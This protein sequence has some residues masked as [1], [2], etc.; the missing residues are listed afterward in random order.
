MTPIERFDS[1]DSARR[2][3]LLHAGHPDL[4]RRIA[5][6]WKL[7]KALVPIPLERGIWR[8]A[9]IEEAN[10]HRRLQVAERARKLAEMRKR[11]E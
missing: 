7:A 1:Y 10:E 3:L 4:H 9:T 11:G 8:F 5:R 6:H 2:A